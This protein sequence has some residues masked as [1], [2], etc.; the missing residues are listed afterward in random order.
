MTSDVL[1]SARD[2]S[3]ERHSESTQFHSRLN[4]GF[5]LR[6]DGAPTLNM[7]PY[8]LVKKKNWLLLRFVDAEEP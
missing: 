7:M 3:E 1:R 4:R 6:P 2:E 8:S 5:L